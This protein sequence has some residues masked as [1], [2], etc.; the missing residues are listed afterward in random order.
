MNAVTEIPWTVSHETM[1][2]MAQE[3]VLEDE[4]LFSE[5]IYAETMEP[6]ENRPSAYFS[7]IST[8]NLLTGILMKPRASDQQL[9]E[10][11]KEVR[12]RYVADHQDTVT[13]EFDRIRA[14]EEQC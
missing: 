12:R 10:A 7:S 4:E 13:R 9:A 8:K 11:W 2:E 1:L 14:E 3:K 5:W 6:T